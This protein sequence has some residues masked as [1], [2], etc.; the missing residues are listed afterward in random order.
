M[1]GGAKQTQLDAV[2]E[3]INQDGNWWS[4]TYADY[5]TSGLGNGRRVVAMPINAGYPSYTVRQIGAFFLRRASDYDQG[6][7][8]EWCAE[9]LGA[10]VQGA[11][12]KGAMDGSGAYVV[13]L[14]Q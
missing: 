7:N 1:T 10:W 4:Q 14:T 2:R 8:K 11:K 9:Y 12:T 6:G 5:V 3:R 13:R